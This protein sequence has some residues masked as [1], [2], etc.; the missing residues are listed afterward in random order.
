M[1]Q[2]GG[3]QYLLDLAKVGSN[4]SDLRPADHQI[5]RAC[6][7]KGRK[8]RSISRLSTLWAGSLVEMDQSRR[9]GFKLDA[10]F[11]GCS[12]GHL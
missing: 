9:E 1:S 12:L 5:R 11:A 7:A 10:T 3:V 4:L 8:A 2:S 6:V